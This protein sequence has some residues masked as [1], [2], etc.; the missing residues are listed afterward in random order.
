METSFSGAN[1][2]VLQ[3][4]ITGEFW[5]PKGLVILI[6]MSLFCMLKQRKRAGT[7]RD[8]QFWC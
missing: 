7:H 3:A 5:D 6:Q 8:L 4:Q 2:A 1:R